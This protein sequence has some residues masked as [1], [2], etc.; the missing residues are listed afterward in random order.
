MF[1]PRTTA[2]VIGVRVLAQTLISAMPALASN[3]RQQST[4]WTRAAMNPAVLNAE[5]A[6]R[7]TVVA[8][9]KSLDD[10]IAAGEDLGFSRTVQC[11]IG[12]PQA[13]EQQ[14]ISFLRSVMACVLSP[15]V[16][17]ACEGVLPQ[18]VLD[19][20][21]KIRDSFPSAGA[22]TGSQGLKIVRDEVA[23]FINE[24]DGTDSARAE[25][26]FLTNGASEGVRVCMTAALCPGD[27][28]LVPVPQYP[29]YSALCTL[30]GVEFAG[31][32]LGEADGFAVTPAS[33]EKA[34]EASAAKGAPPRGLVI[35]NPG[36]PTG[37]TMSKQA[38]ADVIEWCV[39]RGVVLFADEVYQENVKYSDDAE[40]F[41]SFRAVATEKGF[42]AEDGD[43]PLQMVSFHSTSKGFV[44]ECGLRG[45]Y[46]EL[47][48]LEAGVRAE[49][50]KLMSISL[51][52]NVPGQLAVGL[53]VNPPR[54]TDPSGA[55][56]IAERDGILSSLKRR[57]ITVS[58][59]LNALEGVSCLPPDGALY[60][61]PQITL[62]PKACKAAADAG[63][64]PDVYYCLQLVETTGIVVVPGSGFGQAEG[65]H[66]FRTTILPPE[67]KMA[68][69]MRRLGSFHANFMAEHA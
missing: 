51:C 33:L 6:V 35:I 45:G 19:R 29:L 63:M 15:E 39:S 59:G 56:Y 60:A 8:L 12:N 25:D 64:A 47:F 69:V 53:M 23:A 13:L 50:Y 7:G 28:V 67:D 42:K 1:R 24:R 55:Q 66:H 3:S 38:V 62:S 26:V 37:A 10:R 54:P 44:G 16:A 36:N 27:A 49:L 30:L 4:R 20:A 9:A 40:P 43:S 52:S 46:F 34:Y 65:T 68:D 61:F 2:R 31:Y 18:D 5:Y 14:P 41:T 17:K 22:Y 21:A 32:E 58:E 57:A 48:G 11:N